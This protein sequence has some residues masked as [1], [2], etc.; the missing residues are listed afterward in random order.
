MNAIKK[1]FNQY[2]SL[3]VVAKAT[4]WLM[5]CSILQRAFSLITVPVFSRLMSVEQYGQFSAY[6]SWTGLFSVLTTMKLDGAVFN[7][8][9]SQYKAERDSYTSTMQT[10]TLAAAL[11]LCLLYVFFSSFFSF[12]LFSSRS[13]R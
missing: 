1:F 5:V 13:P 7:K 8:G 6:S 4:L 10:V 9:M 3:S 11:V 12:R 2:Q